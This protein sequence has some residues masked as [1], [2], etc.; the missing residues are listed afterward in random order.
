MKRLISYLCIA[1]LILSGCDKWLEVQPYDAIG[2]SQ[3]LSD[4]DGYKLLL[5]G[6]YIE[7]CSDDLYAGALGCEMLEMMGGAYEI[8]TD[9]NVWGDYTDIRDYKY[10]T[11][12]WRSRL[13][14]VWDKAYSLVLNCNKIL[15]NIDS[16]KE[17]F[18]GDNYAV[19]KAEALA[20]RAMLQFDMLR[21]FSSAADPS[22]DAI[23]YYTEV[24]TVPNALLSGSEALAKVFED[25]LEARSLLE[26]TD[27]VITQGR[28]MSEA[29]DGSDNFLR[30]RPL[31]LNY[32]AVTALLARA[33]M[34]KGDY[35]AALGYAREV[36][37][38]VD[39]GIFPSVQRSS[40]IVTSGSPDRIFSTEVLFALSHSYRNN[41]YLNWFSPSRTTY[42]LGMEAGFADNVIYGGGTLTGGYQDDWRNRARWTSSA[43]KRYF[44]SY[45]DLSGAESTV[46]NTMIPLIRTGEMYLIA[47]EASGLV[48]GAAYVNALRRN[49][50]I[51][52]SLQTLTDDLLSYEYIRELYGEGQLFFMYKRRNLPV[53]WGQNGTAGPSEDIFVVPLPDSE[54]N[55]STATE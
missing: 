42:V 53:M 27:P 2:E 36:L 25:L 12:Y 38:A 7:L 6:I 46:E 15:S 9:S 16:S 31:R 22:R 54:K 34:W 32:Y 1:L 30:Y 23:P 18:H 10:G 28:L 13:D 5:N 26:K 33:S 24:T 47:A 44:N 8:G 20:L 51:S 50:G 40:V 37:A 43:G 49:R 21:L 17:L 45:S 3:L 41:L 4:E 48:S 52:S 39:S 19:I 55:N 35:S 11:D 14:D 29:S